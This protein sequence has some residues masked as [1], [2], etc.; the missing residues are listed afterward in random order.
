MI[1]NITVGF[2]RVIHKIQSNIHKWR[3]KNSMILK[4]KIQAK[5]KTECDMNHEQLLDE[6]ESVSD[7]LLDHQYLVDNPKK[8]I[9]YEK[10]FH[11]LGKLLY[12]MEQEKRIAESTFT[13]KKNPFES[14]SWIDEDKSHRAK[15]Y[16]G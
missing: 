16:K 15:G 8:K 10:R 14:T 12:K 11:Y 9:K 6:Y 7:L 3:K 4:R 5:K 2:L 13:N 1:V